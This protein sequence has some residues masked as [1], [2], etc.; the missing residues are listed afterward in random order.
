MLRT[1]VYSALALIGLGIAAPEINGQVRPFP[2]VQ[3]GYQ[4]NFRYQYGYGIYPSYYYSGQNPVPP[5]VI[6]QIRAYVVEYRRPDWHF[7]QTF[8]RTFSANEAQVYTNYL[9][10]LGFRA[11]VHIHSL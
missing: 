5:V 1:A 4:P 7:W 3:P 9:R 11:R 2:S 6:P 10:S 8:R